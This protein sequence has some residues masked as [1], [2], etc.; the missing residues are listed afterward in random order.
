MVTI[1]FVTPQKYPSTSLRRSFAPSIGNNTVVN[2]THSFC[3]H[4]LDYLSE[5]LL[6]IQGILLGTK[7]RQIWYF[8]NFRTASPVTK[9][10]MQDW[11]LIVTRH[12]GYHNKATKHHFLPPMPR[13]ARFWNTHDWSWGLLQPAEYKSLHC[14]IKMKRV[15]E[16][17]EGSEKEQNPDISSTAFTTSDELVSR[18]WPPK[19]ISSKIVCTCQQT[20][21]IE[22]NNLLIN[23]MA[24]W[25]VM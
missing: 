20:D 10:F 8:C 1:L 18:T 16:V 5:V 23:F 21:F 9:H 12:E 24:P 2:E 7:V 6:H 17:E 11:S 3:N 14:C 4:F 19:I 13:R 22:I 15:R 25:K